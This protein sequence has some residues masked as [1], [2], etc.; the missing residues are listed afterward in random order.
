[1]KTRKSSE[2]LRDVSLSTSSLVVDC[3][4]CNLN[5]LYLQDSTQCYKQ[6]TTLVQ[7]VVRSLRILNSLFVSWP[8][9]DF[10]HYDC[11]ACW[12]IDRNF[13]SVRSAVRSFLPPFFMILEIRSTV[14]LDLRRKFH[15]Y[16]DFQWSQISEYAEVVVSQ[17]DF[18]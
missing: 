18:A 3:L 17:S 14:N 7:F 8:C 4:W 1:M 5:N 11:V 2:S 16:C 9:L 13:D 10:Q 12:E 15:T 6:R